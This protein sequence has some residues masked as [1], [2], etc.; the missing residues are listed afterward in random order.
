MQSESVGKNDSIWINF[1]CPLRE[2]P[3]A[4]L[5][6]CEPHVAEE[7]R[8]S[9]CVVNAASHR[10]ILEVLGPHR[11][12]RPIANPASAL[13]RKDIE[14]VAS[15]NSNAPICPDLCPQD[16]SLVRRESYNRET[17]QCWTSPLPWCSR[18]KLVAFPRRLPRRLVNILSMDPW[19]AASPACCPILVFAVALL[20]GVCTAHRL[21]TILTLLAA[22]CS[23]PVCQILHG[24]FRRRHAWSPASQTS[25]IPYLCVCIVQ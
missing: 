8:I 17:I 21:L 5:L 25:A 24:R 1:D 3:A 15:E 14:L 13:S 6:H 19:L 23:H 12:F 20:G 2:S 7:C 10:C 11:T 16:C 9:C 18:T 4:D 22:I